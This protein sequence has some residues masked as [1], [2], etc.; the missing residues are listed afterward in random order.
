MACGPSS[1]TSQTQIG[2]DSTKDTIPPAL[3]ITQPADGSVTDKPATTVVGTTESTAKLTVNGQ[4]VTVGGDGSFSNAVTLVSGKNTIS[5]SAIDVA[6]N[7]TDKVVYITYNPPPPPVVQQ[8]PP[9]QTQEIT[10]YV[11]KTGECYHSSGCQYLRQ[12]CIPISLSAAKQSYR[13]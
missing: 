5:T 12:S 9:A 10:V 11:T 8:A 1:T 3:S 6:G 13:P 2:P 4:S 7:K